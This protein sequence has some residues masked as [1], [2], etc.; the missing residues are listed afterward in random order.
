M[1]WEPGAGS[2]GTKSPEA[3]SKSYVTVQFLT[4]SCRKFRIS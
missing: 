2:L 4:F 1:R 3:D